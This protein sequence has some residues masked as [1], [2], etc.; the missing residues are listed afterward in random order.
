MTLGRPLVS[1]GP[2]GFMCTGRSAPM[3]GPLGLWAADLFRGGREQEPDVGHTRGEP[4]ASRGGQKPRR[5]HCASKI[6]ED[7]T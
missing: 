1:P 6:A 3:H 2:A 7:E 4:G 5:P